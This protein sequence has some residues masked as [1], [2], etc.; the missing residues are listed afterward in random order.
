[1]NHALPDIA[2]TAARIRAILEQSVQRFPRKDRYGSGADLRNG[3]RE[4]V[5]LALVAWNEP[6][7]RLMRVRELSTAIDGLKLDMQLA[8]DVNAFRSNREFEA[9]GRQ[10][11][12][13]GK[14]CGGWLKELHNK[15]QDGQGRKASVQRAP[16]LSGRSASDHGANP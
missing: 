10:I 14:Q 3:A 2:R 13:L 6:Q 8:K 5:R 4:V 1:M 12:D 15:G 7:R 16:T 9:I 11:V